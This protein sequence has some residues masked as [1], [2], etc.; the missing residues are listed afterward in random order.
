MVTMARK[1]KQAAT[2]DASVLHLAW[3]KQ[4]ACGQVNQATTGDPKRVTC[5]RCR[6]IDKATRNIRKVGG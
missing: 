3:G 6:Y 1:T 2:G 4:P 5:E